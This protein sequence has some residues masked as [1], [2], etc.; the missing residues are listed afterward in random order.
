MA[1]FF[2]P[3]PACDRGKQ[4]LQALLIRLPERP[5]LTAARVELPEAALGNV[6]G[7]GPLLELDEQGAYWDGQ[8]IPGADTT[9]R[10]VWL[11]SNAT[12][13]QGSAVYIAA[14]P[15]IDVQTLRTFLLGLPPSSQARLLVRMP[16]QS[17]EAAKD[18]S[19]AAR[20]L[21]ERDPKAREQLAEQG[22]A[23]HSRCTAL[24]G[25]ISAANGLG[26]SE[27]WTKVRQGALN[28]LDS[29]AC[30]DLDTEGLKALLLAEQ[31]AGTATVAAL[32]VTFLRDQRCGASM[33]LRSMRKLLGQ[34][35]LFNEEF[36]GKFESDALTFE[37]VLT[38][39]RLLGYFCN[40]LPGETL[41]SLQRARSTLYLRLPG[42][43]T[44]QGVRF[45]P[46][47]TGAPMGTLR[48]LRPGGA[49]GTAF[50]YWQAAEEIRVYGPA[51]SDPPSKPT[52][53]REWPC[54]THR[55][56][57]GVDGSSIEL[58]QERWFSDEESCRKAP[59]ETA[60]S[61]CMLQALAK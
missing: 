44:C 5:L 30:Q 11:H 25:A 34:V 58:E 24:N 17:S 61:G 8:P 7:E 55:K 4:E 18:N 28:T 35:E 22:F 51:L 9:T 6:P 31:R 1:Q 45:E 27:R 42:S 59:A 3:G 38:H 19:F 47:S 37:Q 32:P 53:T 13:A 40:A 54:D 49:P 60:V 29:C 57:T 16:S 52:D 15:N 43:E 12:A 41:A 46:L 26:A 39:E 48:Q 33:P 56:L 20:L 21:Q 10:A 14:H 36:S 50:H 2:A 23:Q